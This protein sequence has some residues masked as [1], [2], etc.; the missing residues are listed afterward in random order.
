MS[1]GT[2]DTCDVW[3]KI[4]GRYVYTKRQTSPATSTE[5]DKQNRVRIGEETNSACVSKSYQV[6]IGLVVSTLLH[7]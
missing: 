4:K 5:A 3:R 1:T 2:E 6:L 7:L